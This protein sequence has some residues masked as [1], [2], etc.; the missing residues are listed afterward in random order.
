MNPTATLTPT[1]YAAQVLAAA[2]TAVMQLV[3]DG[4]L[5]MPADQAEARQMV[6]TAAR[7]FLSQ[8][9]TFRDMLGAAVWERINA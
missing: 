1:E 6:D 5:P 3:T 8:D 4:V 7:L 2:R 9:A